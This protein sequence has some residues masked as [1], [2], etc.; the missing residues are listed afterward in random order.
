MLNLSRSFRGAQAFDTDPPKPG[1]LDQELPMNKAQL[2]KF[3]ALL[4]EKRD[5]IV[6]KAK[7]T[8]DE[9]MTLDANDLPDEMDLASSEYLQSFTFRLRG[10]EKSFLD[11]ITKALAKI[12]DGTFGTCEEC[13]EDISIQRLEARPE[14]TLCIRCKEDQERMEKD[15]G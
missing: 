5:E 10:R 9:D 3:R 1:A 8:L 11:K 15:Y 14:T 12:D 6:K 2:K 13:G 7:Q 4:E